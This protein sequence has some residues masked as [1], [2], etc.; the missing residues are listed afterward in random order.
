MGYF[1]QPLGDQRAGDGG[2]E[3]ILALINRI[4]AEHREDEIAH[5]FLA[6][7]LDIDVLDAEHL[8]LFARRF[9]LFALA[10]IG[11]EGHHLAIIGFPE[12]FEDDGGVEPA[13][14]GQH[15]LF[16]VFCHCVVPA[17]IMMTG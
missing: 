14:I 13:R 6:Q 16:D 5:E 2:A 9:Q 4:G 17:E 12:P 15:D 8:G 1:N 7:I 3:Q 10:Q 11:G